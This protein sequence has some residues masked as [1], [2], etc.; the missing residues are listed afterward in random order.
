MSR[1]MDRSRLNRDTKHPLS[2]RDSARLPRRLLVYVIAI[3]RGVL[4]RETRFRARPV[5]SRHATRVRHYFENFQPLFRL[6]RAPPERIKKPVPAVARKSKPRREKYRR[7]EIPRLRD[8]C[9]ETI[10][11]TLFLLPLLDSKDFR[12]FLLFLN[13][14]LN[15]Y[16]ILE[17]VICCSK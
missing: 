13:A 5:V 10:P 7:F 15:C 6:V 9:S 1:I 8:P 12:G 2:R 4:A 17:T 14:N 16:F 11:S 3:T